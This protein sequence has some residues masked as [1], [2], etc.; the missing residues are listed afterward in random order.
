MH[1][2]HMHRVFTSR[3]KTHVHHLIIRKDCTCCSLRARNDDRLCP[4]P[5]SDEPAAAAPDSCATG[6]S[7]RCSCRTSRD[8]HS[9]RAEDASQ[10]RRRCASHAMQQGIP[11]CKGGKHLERP[12]MVAVLQRLQHAPQGCRTV[13]PNHQAGSRNDFGRRAEVV[14]VLRAAI[15]EPLLENREMRATF[16][17]LE[18]KRAEKYRC[19]TSPP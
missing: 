12:E 16:R 4:D 11:G 5:C 17:S 15:S 19:R 7:A 14:L 3:E 10:R 8:N 6:S 13:R 2:L 9:R 18:P 1:G